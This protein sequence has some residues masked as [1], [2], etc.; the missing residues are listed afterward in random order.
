MRGD[1]AQYG[2]TLVELMIAGGLAVSLLVSSSVALTANTH[3]SRSEAGL[4]ATTGA[5]LVAAQAVEQA[6]AGAWTSS[7]LAGISSVCSDG[8]ANANSFPSNQ[9]P[10]VSAGATKV[11]YYGF[12]NNSSTSY[13]F[14]I[15]FTK[16]S[17]SLC[18]LEID[19]EP[20]YGCSPKPCATSAVFSMAGVSDAG[21]PFVY[22]YDN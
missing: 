15:S 13:T 9:G 6:L 3:A 16:C 21:T 22:Y 12:R 7:S 4:G 18:T 14:Q 8:T 2:M 10:F 19:Q 1:R 5:A 17:G 11:V 20:A